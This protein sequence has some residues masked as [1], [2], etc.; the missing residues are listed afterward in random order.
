M[1]PPKANPASSLGNADLGVSTGLADNLGGVVPAEI[2]SRVGGAS[3]IHLAQAVV[4]I[5]QVCV[6]P[7]VRLINAIVHL[8]GSDYTGV[9]DAVLSGS[10]IDPAGR[11]SV[12]QTPGGPVGPVM[13]KLRSPA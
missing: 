7:R 6:A 8:Y 12:P 1:K 9:G 3:R 4:D 2:G 5:L 13:V 10:D 11:G